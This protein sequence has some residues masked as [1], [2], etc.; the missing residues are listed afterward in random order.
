M[1]MFTEL[2]KLD[3][4]GKK[5]KVFTTHEG[6][7]LGTVVQDVKKICQGADVLDSIAI[8]GS[9]VHEAKGRIEKWIK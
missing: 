7:G 6:S 2:E 4:S 3:F 5:I 8:Q 1:S 9:T